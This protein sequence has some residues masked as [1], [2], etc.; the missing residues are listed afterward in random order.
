MKRGSHK[1]ILCLVLAV[2]LLVFQVI[3]VFPVAEVYADTPSVLIVGDSRV[4]GM[5][6]NGD[7][8]G[9]GY[10]VVGLGG[11][12][13]SALTDDGKIKPGMGSANNKSN[14]PG[15]ETLNKNQTY[16]LV[17]KCKGVKTI[18]IMMGRNGMAGCGGGSSVE[19]SSSNINTAVANADSVYNKGQ[20][21]ASV[22]GAK[23]LYAECI[24]DKS[25]HSG[26]NAC[27]DAFNKELKSK[28]GSVIAIA[29]CKTDSASDPLHPSPYVGAI[30]KIKSAVG[31]VS[32]K[33][34]TSDSTAGF[35]FFSDAEG[36]KWTD[37]TQKSNAQDIWTVLKAD[38]Y[39]D[40]AVASVIGN[41]VGESGLNPLSE[42]TGGIGLFGFD[43]AAGSADAFM[44]YCKGSDHASHK[45]HTYTVG[46]TREACADAGCH[47]AY[48]M[49]TLESRFKT[50]TWSSHYNDQVSSVSSLKTMVSNKEIPASVNITNTLDGFKSNK[51]LE[52]CLIHFYLDAETAAA[53]S[54]FWVGNSS[55]DTSDGTCKDFKNN[56][57]KRY[58]YALLALKEFGGSIGSATDG[59][60]AI[61]N[62]LYMDGVWDE[63]QLSAYCRLHEIDL[64]DILDDA[65]I[66]KLNNK[67]LQSLDDWKQAIEKAPWYIRLGRIA[68]MGIGIF[69]VVWGILLY[70]AYWFDKINTY[71]DLDVVG[72]LTFRKLKVA[73]DDSECT[74]KLSDISKTESR[75][76]NHKYV[77]IISITAIS[78]GVFLISGLAFT[79]LRKLVN[80][81]LG[82]GGR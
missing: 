38:G 28:A 79:L 15:F 47:A 53:T 55:C 78:F 6:N 9:T 1:R 16:D 13:I 10:Y 56:F 67:E 29:N 58:N 54:P 77:L 60:N 33:D 81:V 31:G 7:F 2:I 51:V 66:E 37:D 32:S 19:A 14:I 59:S 46:G 40:A 5:L 27:I 12:T 61:V 65:T 18:V 43:V 57:H 50:F 8:D 68:V 26:C 23:V 20:K 45:K 21:W 17:S 76:I 64:T 52:D 62:Q 41:G 44:N 11:S 39:S 25:S 4:V 73:F 30:D 75:T 48:F 34:G 82:V 74:F 3:G 22:Y 71:I 24:K 80:I 49:G 72:L 42:G 35:D 36:N 70:C 69:S 63:D